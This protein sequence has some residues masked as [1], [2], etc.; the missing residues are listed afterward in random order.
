MLAEH[1]GEAVWAAIAFAVRP[2]FSS[3]KISLPGQEAQQNKN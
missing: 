1:I 3:P 2:L